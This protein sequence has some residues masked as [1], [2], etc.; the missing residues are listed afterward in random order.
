MGG[1]LN[2]ATSRTGYSIST[3]SDSEKV[4]NRFQECIQ[5]AGGSL[6][7]SE[8][9]MRK[10]L[11]GGASLDNIKSATLDH[12]ITWN[13]SKNETAEISAPTSTVGRAYPL[14]RSV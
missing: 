14:G 8:A 10:D 3:K 4:D 5:R 7:L 13:F 11:M 12:I 2:A 1:G 9:H 6:I